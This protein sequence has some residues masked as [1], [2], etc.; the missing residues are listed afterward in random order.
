MAESIVGHFVEKLADYTIAAISRQFKYMFRYNR[1]IQNLRSEVQD[2]ENKRNDVQSSVDGAKRNALVIKSEVDAWLK[3]ADDLKKEAD[4]VLNSTTNSE[5]RCLYFRCP[6]LK[7]R[8]SLSRNATKKATAIV[9]LQQKGK[10][11]EVR[12]RAPLKLSSFHG[13][14]ALKTR[15][16]TKE[17]IIKALKD[18]DISIV[19][20]CGL[21]GVGKTTMA[22][23]VMTEVK[24][25][26]FDEV[27]MGVVSKD[28]DIIRIQDKLADMLSLKIDEKTNEIARAAR[29]AER[30]TQDNKKRILVILDDVWTDIDLKTLGIPSSNRPE[31]LKILLTSRFEYVC[32]RMGAQRNIEVGVLPREEAFALFQDVA[33]I[34]KISSITTEL[35]AIAEQVAEEC[36]GLPLALVIA[37]KTLRDSELRVWRNALN[38]LR[39]SQHD[40]VV[41]SSIELSYNYLK[42]DEHRSLLLLCSLFLEDE[43]IPIESLVRYARGLGLFKYTETLLDTRDRTYAISDNLKSCHL[44]LSGYREEEVKLHDVIRD[45]CLSIASKGEHRYL[46]KHDIRTEWPEHDNHESYSAISL[47][48]QR[49]ILLPSRLQYGNLKFLRVQC[50]SG[51]RKI[52]ITGEFFYY[53][54]ELR[55]IDFS[56]FQI[57]SPIRLPLGLQTLCL[58]DCILEIEMSSFGSLKK[59]EILTFLDSSLPVDFSRDE[60]VELSN[61]RLLDLRFKKGPCL[62][63]PGFLFGMK[64]LEDLYL[65]RCLYPR[66]EEKEHIIEELSSLKDLNTLQIITDDTR[67]LLQLL[68]SCSEKLE[69]LERFQIYKSGIDPS[70]RFH[71]DFRRDLKLENIDRN[72]LLE[73]RIK[74]LMRRSDK[75]FLS[76]VI[77]WNNPVIE[78]VEDGF[79]N[80]KSLELHRLDSEYLIDAAGSISSGMFGNLES[81]ALENMHY[82]KAIHNGNLPR[83][84]HVTRGVSEPALFYNLKQIIVYDCAKIKRLFSESVAKCM[85]NLQSLYL[86]S[87]RSLE[88]VISMDT[89]EN[90]ITEPLSFPK[91]KKVVLDDLSSFISFRSQPNAVGLRR[92]LLNQVELPDM[93]NLEISGS[94]SI[95][96]ILSVET[97]FGSPNRLWRMRVAICDN[98]VNIAQSN[99]IKLLQNLGTLVVTECMALNV[100]FDFEGLNVNKDYEE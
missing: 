90:E 63:P 4:E 11:D 8:Y 66:Y 99:S 60:M 100:I 67:V 58:N 47:T 93:E 73:P 52:D 70:Y 96:K 84:E 9:E 89:Q 42:S 65:G 44:L 15:M 57:R 28:V 88:E 41:Y 81:L 49:R 80:L 83:M 20:V 10:F 55:V 21:P 18:K 77:G 95:E 19:G 37:G 75:L 13:S 64:K 22:K 5:M 72:M 91:L 12:R 16:S 45:F 98:L 32:K 26:L 30:L 59:L 76:N 40:D 50:Y 69:K 39:N 54:Q 34:S 23:E 6:N 25:G 79:I 87:C 61:L 3:K 92:T 7:T 97:P 74:S 51:G 71:R 38:Q 48:F 33:E 62:L 36:K 85:V 35:K 82:L 1:N 31:G 86:W 14:E 29:L 46:V 2:L 43:S 56:G 27:A 53:M 17:D 68:Q 94:G 24:G 78:L